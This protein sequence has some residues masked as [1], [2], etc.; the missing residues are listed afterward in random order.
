[1]LENKISNSQ[2]GDGKKTLQIFLQKWA[3]IACFLLIVA[4]LVAQYVYLMGNLAKP[5]GPLFY[6]LADFLYGPLWAACLVTIVIGLRERT[7]GQAARRM[8]LGLTIAILAA[9]MM[10]LVSCVRSSSRHYHLLHPNIV[11][12]M[13]TAGWH[14]LGWALV[15]VGSATWTTH[16]TPRSLTIMFFLSGFLSWFVFIFPVLEGFAAT[17]S[18]VWAAWL[19]IFFWRTNLGD[20]QT[21]E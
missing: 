18:M 19:G 8:S 2:A 16:A 9:S 3:G 17:L 12:G 13:V 7:D 20:Q 14:F 4:Y 10:I 1:M 5:L 11:Q 15:L 6:A 21:K